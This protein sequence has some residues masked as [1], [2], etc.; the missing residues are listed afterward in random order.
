[1]GELLLILLG[2]AVFRELPISLHVH[3]EGQMKLRP[4][5]VGE[6]S[7]ALTMS[8]VSNRFSSALPHALREARHFT[9]VDSLRFPTWARFEPFGSRTWSDPVSS[10]ITHCDQ[11]SF[12]YSLLTVSGSSII[13]SVIFRRSPSFSETTSHG[14]CSEPWVRLGRP[15]RFARRFLSITAGAFIRAFGYVRGKRR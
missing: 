6:T 7:F 4:K 14:T 13:A 8:A 10:S 3:L 11:D 15:I 2:V 1:M 12:Y 9:L 5:V